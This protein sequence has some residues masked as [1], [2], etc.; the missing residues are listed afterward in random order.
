MELLADAK[1]SI[2][3]VNLDSI[4]TMLDGPAAHDVWSHRHEGVAQD[5][6]TAAV[7]A[8]L[9]KG[10]DVIVDNTNLGPRS[11]APLKVV[12]SEFDDLTFAVHDFT[13]VPVEE[14]IRRDAGRE[15]P[16]GE[17]AIQRLHKRHQGAAKGGWK[18][19]P[20]WLA[21]RF[22]PTP[23]VA[24]PSLPRAVLVDIDGTLA[25]MRGRGPYEFERCTEDAPNEPVLDTVRVL[26]RSGRQ[27]VLLSGR[28][29]E[30]RSQTRAWLAEHAVP[31]SEL[32]MRPAGDTRRD[33]IVKA[34]LFDTHVRYRYAVSHSLDDRDRVVQL[35][36]R[37]GLPCWQ[38]A[39]GN[40]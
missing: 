5:M 33:D 30:Y 1:G 12:F 36:R 15:N 9:A 38:V 16:V 21:D 4:R 34:E 29:E 18:L 22:V 13:D 17:E 27:I 14:C 26:Y 6:Q 35:W 23:Y 11:L 3:R 28:G 32:Y 2:R 39:P 7:R 20:A 8:C 19:T 10:F 25:L 24:D 37:M 40:F 31:Y